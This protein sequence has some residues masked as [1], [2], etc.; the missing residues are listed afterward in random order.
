M[1]FFNAIKEKR[2]L[3]GALRGGERNHSGVGSTVFQ[4]PEVKG[5]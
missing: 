3:K 5:E 2:K 4:D 1:I